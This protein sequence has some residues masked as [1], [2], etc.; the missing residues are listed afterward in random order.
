M[1]KHLAIAGLAH[2]PPQERVVHQPADETDRAEF[3]Y[4]RSVEGNF[5]DAVKDIACG[6]RCLVPLYRICLH[7]NDVVRLARAEKREERRVTDIAA[8]PVRRAANLDRLEHKGEARRG[9]YHVRRDFVLA[10]DPDLA[11]MHIR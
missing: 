3:G 8:V 7:K 10:E 6:L 2:D 11:G 9:H 5:V 1:E 4:E